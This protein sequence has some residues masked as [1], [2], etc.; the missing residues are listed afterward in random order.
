MAGWVF[1]GNPKIFDMD[2]YLSRYT[3]LIYWRTNRYVDQIGLGDSVFIWRAGA[4]AGVVAVGRVTELPIA[5]RSVAH[6]E[7]LGTDLWVKKAGN[8]D[9]DELKTGIELH[10]IR[11]SVDEG[12]VL[13]ENVAADL[14]L[15]TSMIIK[16]PNGTVFKLS[17]DECDALGDHWGAKSSGRLLDTLPEGKRV[18][19]VHYSRERSG[20][21]RQDKLA[22]FREQHGA[23][24]CEIC[25]FDDSDRHPEPFTGRAF[26][27]H[28]RV[29]LSQLAGVVRTGLEDLAVLCANCHRAVHA[30]LNVEAN[31]A[32]MSALYPDKPRLA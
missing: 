13:R 28:H 7:A 22:S 31:F 4:Q 24:F 15:A 2:D 3:R 14:V 26:E 30:N 18:L 8:G 11:L 32:V 12:M 6:R 1:Q 23:L 19:H 10:D 20:R 16:V 29:P 27:V 21:L 17:S 9:P 25:G 5:A